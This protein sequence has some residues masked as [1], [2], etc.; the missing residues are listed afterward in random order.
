M[1]KLLILSI[2]IS[3]TGCSSGHSIQSPDGAWIMYRMSGLDLSNKKLMKGMP[4]FRFDII[5]GKF[6]GHAGCNQLLSTIELSD[7]SIKFGKILH[8]EMACADM[9]VENAVLKVL[10]ESTLLYEVNDAELILTSPDGIEM[11]FTKE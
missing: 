8:T 2:V 11:R 4:L 9:E 3:L 7:H 5:E 6:S 10:T 1:I